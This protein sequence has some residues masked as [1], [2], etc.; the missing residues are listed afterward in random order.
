MTTFTLEVPDELAARLNELRDHLPALLSEVLNSGT[1]EQALRR[2]G[3]T[4][5]RQVY[6]EMIE[7]L[8]SGPTPDEI[9]AHKA[10]QK[11]QERLGELL[12]KN[13]EGDVTDAECAELDLFESVEDLM[14]LLKAKARLT[15]VVRHQSGRSRGSI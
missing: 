9:I 13:G 6:D 8:A 12:Y 15:D 2:L 4:P 10:S 11:M 1:G 5:S 3:S 7:F 14:G